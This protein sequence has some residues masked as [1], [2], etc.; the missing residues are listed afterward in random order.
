MLLSCKHSGAGALC[1]GV[2]RAPGIEPIWEEAVLSADRSDFMGRIGP[3]RDV[4]AVILTQDIFVE[5]AC[6]ITV[7]PGSHFN[8]G[9]HSHVYLQVPNPTPCMKD[10]SPH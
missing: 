1:C 5:L 2:V 9:P 4:A 6:R 10:F 8:K 7:M 3:D